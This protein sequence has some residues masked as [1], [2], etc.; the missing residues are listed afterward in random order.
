[1]SL[2]GHLAWGLLF[3][4]LFGFSFTVMRLSVAALLVVEGLAFVRLLRA[5]GVAPG[6]CTAAAL[7]LLGHPLHFFHSFTFMT[8]IP[9]LAWQ[10]VCLLCWALALTRPEG[11]PGVWLALGSLA[12]GEGFLIRQN[13]LLLPLALALYLALWD[14]RLLRPSLL[15]SAFGPFALVAGLFTYWYRFVHGPTKAYQDS[16]AAILAYLTDP[17]WDRLPYYF[18]SQAVYVALFLLP[19]AFALP[20]PAW[21]RYHGKRRWV[22]LASA[23]GLGGMLLTYAAAGR[24][25]PYLR[26]VL[27]PYGL[28]FVNEFLLGDRDQLW[29]EPVAWVLSLAGLG[30]LLV[31]VGRLLLPRTGDPA[32]PA[33]RVGK[34]LGVLL[35]L[36][37]A[38]CQV[39][40]PILFDRHLL[41]LSPAV[42]ALFCL[43][44]GPAPRVRLAIYV[45]CLA[46]FLLYSVLTSR[47]LHT[48]SRLAFRA[49]QDL[50]RAGVDP[51][52]IDGG[53]AFCGWHAY[54]VP[55]Q[56]D[57]GERVPAESWYVRDLSLPVQPRYV[58]SLSSRQR[59]VPP[60]DF[61]VYPPFGLNPRLRY[62]VSRT[63]PYPNCWPW[64]TKT[65]YILRVELLPPA[66][67]QELPALPQGP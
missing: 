39:T 16:V 28:F 66:P 8:D 6:L 29:G 23:L 64:E 67:G 62:G 49:G 26:N 19:L 11:R 53:Y 14:R 50:I 31:L 7:A 18:Y 9:A 20:L 34:L 1:M 38:Y 60:K 42:L 25:F 57:G 43:W 63:Y 54:G 33:D 46:A 44:S 17:P 59:V 27:T 5:C 30:A 65:L 58:L 47:D 21:D 15:L 10:V 37:F 52:H 4:K 45:P 13:A 40:Q 55:P 24:L 2:V 36:E 56:A 3:T 35:A 32:A 12:A 22:L 61:Q 41:L 48:V 51:L